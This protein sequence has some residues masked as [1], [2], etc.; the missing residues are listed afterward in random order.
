MRAQTEIAIVLRPI[1]LRTQIDVASA[2]RTAETYVPQPID[3]QIVSRL[4]YRRS[5][6]ALGCWCRPGETTSIGRTAR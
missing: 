3:H 6:T 2:R 4:R 1:D 5:A